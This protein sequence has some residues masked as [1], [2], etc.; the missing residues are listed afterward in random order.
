MA[1][2]RGNAPQ[3]G[4]PLPE[5]SRQLFLMGSATTQPAPTEASKEGSTAL[6]PLPGVGAC[7]TVV[8]AVG[9]L[10]AFFLF[11]HEGGLQYTPP[12]GI[13]AFAVFYVVA[14]AAERCAELFSPLLPKASMTW[15][16]KKEAAAS[17][18][19]AIVRALNPSPTPANGGK[20]ANPAEKQAKV[21]QITVNRRAIYF[22]LAAALGMVFCGYAHANFLAAI[23]VS[24]VQD[25]QTAAWIILSLAI[26]GLVVGG[27]S[28]GLH[29]LITNLT[30]TTEKK[31][32]PPETGGLS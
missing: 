23:G 7:A 17:R 29:S 27:G 18:D 6:L 11:S 28:D 13:G 10:V 4:I 30:K 26:T 1:I 5:G 12:A 16:G 2:F 8:F 21:D 19:R 3:A 9:L 31:D 15:F 20:A 22:A 25:G 24:P 14:Q 32:T